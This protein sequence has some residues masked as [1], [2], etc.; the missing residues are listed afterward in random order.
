MIP[1]LREASDIFGEYIDGHC[2]ELEMIIAIEDETSKALSV[3]EQEE[4]C[5]V[6]VYA[7]QHAETISTMSKSSE[8]KI[9][10]RLKIDAEMRVTCFNQAIDT[11][12]EDIKAD[13]SIITGM[14]E[15]HF[16]KKEW[17]GYE[18]IKDLVDKARAGVN[19][20]PTVVAEAEA[21]FIQMGQSIRLASTVEGVKEL[22]ETL[23]T[24]K[25]KAMKAMNNVK[26]IS[27]G[28][29]HALKKKEKAEATALSIRG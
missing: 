11:A 13:V 21:S 23:S 15:D 22:L 18:S 7:A 6:S 5:Q 19:S 29:K 8:D 3:L 25:G 4:A 17:A 28:I 12:G 16:G 14:A 1:G 2:D 9:I 27:M 20:F 24:A 26:S 10:R